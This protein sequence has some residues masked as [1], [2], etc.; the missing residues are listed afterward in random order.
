MKDSEFVCD[1][2][3]LDDVIIIL[4]DGRY[5]ITKISEKAFFDKGIYYI[6]IYKRNDERTIY[7]ML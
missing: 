6:G 7:N 3:N 4:K 5:K 2:S 1:C